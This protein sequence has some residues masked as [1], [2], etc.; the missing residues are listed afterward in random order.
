MRESHPPGYLLEPGYLFFTGEPILLGCVLG[1]SVSVCLWDRRLRSG[2]MCHFVYPATRDPAQ[3]T[4]RYGNVAI[5]ALLRMME[6]AGSR[7]ADLEAQL[8]GGGLR[9]LGR[10]EGVGGENVRVARQLLARRGI[11]IVREE[12]GRQTGRKVVFDLRTGSLHVQ[13]AP[14][15]RH[16]DW[17]PE[18][19]AARGAD[20][21]IKTA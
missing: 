13:A 21:T 19:L 20:Q 18:L 3:A 14:R 11:P 12:V 2:G 9:D 8:V 16:S 15:T 1:C 10:G 17:V 5:A 6:R 4:P 7:R